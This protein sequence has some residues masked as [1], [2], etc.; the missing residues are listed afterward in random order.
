L[1]YSDVASRAVKRLSTG[2]IP[3]M[4]G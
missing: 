1:R 4:G 3:G 2:L